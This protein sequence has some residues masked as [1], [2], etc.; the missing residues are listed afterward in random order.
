MILEI[1]FV[2]LLNRKLHQGGAE[3]SALVF[4]RHCKCDRTSL[5]GGIAAGVY[6]HRD[7]GSQI[8][9]RKI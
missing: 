1:V 5:L 3:S 2:T 8:E 9:Q 4:T 7:E 6:V